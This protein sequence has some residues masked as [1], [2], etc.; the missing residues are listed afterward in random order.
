MHG[1]FLFKIKKKMAQMKLAFCQLIKDYE[2][3]ARSVMTIGFL[4]LY[5]TRI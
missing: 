4:Y 2:L 1:V 5:R 3:A